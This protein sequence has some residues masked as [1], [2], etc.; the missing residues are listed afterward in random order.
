MEKTQLHLFG[1]NASDIK[2]LFSSKLE[3]F[4]TDFKTHQGG[5]EIIEIIG[6]D[7]DFIAKEIKAFFP[8]IIIG[9]ILEAIVELLKQR[10]ET[11]TV[12]ESCTG[13]R[14]ASLITSVSGS[15]SVFNGSMVTY[16]NNLKHKWI[17]VSEASLN[18]FGA[19]S[20]EV[21]QE[22][23]LGILKMADAT[24]ALSISG[25]AGP[26]G[27]S[28]EKPVGTVYIAYANNQGFLKS[29]RLLL[30]GNRNEIQLSAS[31][32]ALRLFLQTIKTA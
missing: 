27:G 1:V 14:V 11:I 8:K 12:A 19:V 7:A 4:K 25:I 15:S 17:E 23:A 20:S 2:Q 13:G 26:T 3:D 28:K 22:M 31:Y 18:A 16:S 30:N 6:K 21:V 29:E 10:G 5:W 32:H 9:D 24:H